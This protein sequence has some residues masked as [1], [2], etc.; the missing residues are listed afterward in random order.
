METT[1]QKRRH[2]VFAVL[3]RVMPELTQRLSAGSSRDFLLNE[4]RL[5]T[6]GPFHSLAG[7]PIQKNQGLAN[8]GA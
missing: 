1:P 3:L 7:I 4:R 2:A 5:I 6:H 8:S